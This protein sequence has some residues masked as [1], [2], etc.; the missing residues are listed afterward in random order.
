MSSLIK[1][2]LTKKF[3]LDPNSKT[4]KVPNLKIFDFEKKYVV[5]LPKKSHNLEFYAVIV[6]VDILI[7]T[8]CKF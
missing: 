4:Q 3:Y 5:V 2:V 6:I 1:R 7:L 8:V